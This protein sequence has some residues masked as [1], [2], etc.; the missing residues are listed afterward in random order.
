M[1]KHLK[2]FLSV[3]AFILM[4]SA[5]DNYARVA[6]KGTIEQK[7]EYAIKAYDKGQYSRALPL[8]EEL[9]TVY[10]G[11]ENGEKVLYYYAYS[12][13][14]TGDYILSGYHFKNFA[15]SFPNSPKTEECLYMSA[16][17][18]Y[19]T[20]PG[21]SLDQTD[22]RA[23]IR[24]FQAFVNQFPKSTRVAEANEIIGKLHNKLEIKAY[25]I[26]KQYYHTTNYKSAIVAIAN[27]TKDF[28]DS[29]YNEEL[30]FLLVKSHYLL[31]INS[32]DSKKAERLQST[33][34]AYQKFVD[35][36][37]KSS[38]LKDAGSIY[39]SALKLKQKLKIQTS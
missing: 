34:D 9:I 32:I 26:A 13:Y 28:P 33:V 8:L 15:R 39:D 36:Y 11:T 38:Y 30:S 21:Y 22:T 25:E 17:C 10:R 3:S 29:K 6:K 23:A 35:K 16:Y 20:S 18:Y 19:L 7:Y 37:P 5:C 31:T 24:E 12:N 2:Y 4:L 1:L 14:N 27:V